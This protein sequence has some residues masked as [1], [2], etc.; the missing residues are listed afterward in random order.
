MVLNSLINFDEVVNQFLWVRGTEWSATVRA[1]SVQGLE[2]VGVDV[3]EE[4]QADAFDL[5]GDVAVAG[6]ADHGA[7]VAGEDAA[8]DADA[9]RGS[10]VAYIIYLAAGRVVGRQELQQIHLTLRY[11][12]YLF[13][14]GVAVHPHRDG[15]GVP[16]SIGLKAQGVGGC[17]A[18]EDYV[19][20]DGALS[21]VA[22]RAGHRLGREVDFGAGRPQGFGGAEVLACANGKPFFGFGHR[23]W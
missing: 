16:A 3:G 20:N 1:G 9:L 2:E 12:L 23:G 19:G 10:E 4:D 14:V 15:T 7:F 5:D 18:D 22:G 6:Y 17:G 13:A 8:G 21:P 11:G